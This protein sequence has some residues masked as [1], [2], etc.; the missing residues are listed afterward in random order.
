MKRIDLIIYSNKCVYISAS[1]QVHCRVLKRLRLC[2][3][4]AGSQKVYIIGRAAKKRA[5]QR[6]TSNGKS[7]KCENCLV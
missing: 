2:T 7:G 6:L 5:H 1:F 4:S 3:G